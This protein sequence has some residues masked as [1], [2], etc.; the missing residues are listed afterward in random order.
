MSTNHARI[1]LQDRGSLSISR[2]SFWGQRIPG[3]CSSLAYSSSLRDFQILSEKAYAFKSIAVLMISLCI[4]QPGTTGILAPT[5]AT[6]RTGLDNTII[7]MEAVRDCLY[8]DLESASQAMITKIYKRSEFTF[9]GE[10]S[11]VIRFAHA[12]VTVADSIGSSS[13][14]YPSRDLRTDTGY[15][16]F[17][18]SCKPDLGSLFESAFAKELPTGRTQ[19]ILTL[20][21]DLALV[22]PLRCSFLKIGIL[23]GP[24]N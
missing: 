22:Q 11:F 19:E 3:Y 2:C 10:V 8:A 18:C 13:W 7:G 6:R 4:S 5:S 17:H 20:V 23:R 21:V 24:E 14:Q 12:L 15:R 9:E 16:C 1:P